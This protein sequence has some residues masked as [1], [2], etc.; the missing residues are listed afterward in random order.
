MPSHRTLFT[1][2]RF[3]SIQLQCTEYGAVIAA[4]WQGYGCRGHSS[5]Y[6]LPI[7]KLR[8]MQRHIDAPD[9]HETDRRRRQCPLRKLSGSECHVIRVFVP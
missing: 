6:R 1:S 2:R 7:V 8:L 9:P 4:H 5:L 3:A